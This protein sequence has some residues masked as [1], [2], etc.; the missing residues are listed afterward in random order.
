MIASRKTDEAW[1]G[2]PAHVEDID[3]EVL[4]DVVQAIRQ[5]S[6]SSIGNTTSPT[7]PVTARTGTPSLSTPSAEIVPLADQD[8]SRGPVG[9]G[10]S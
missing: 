5:A 2:S 8:S 4:L 1:P 9:D 10:P 7:L 3:D 6:T